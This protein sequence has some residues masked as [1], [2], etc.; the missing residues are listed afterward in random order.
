LAGRLPRSG[1]Y[2]CAG[3]DAY[4]LDKINNSH[5]AGIK[6]AIYK[7]MIVNININESVCTV[8][9]DPASATGTHNSSHTGI[10]D[11]VVG[12]TFVDK[13]PLGQGVTKGCP[14]KPYLSSGD[15]ND[16]VEHSPLSDEDQKFF[17]ELND[18][19]IGLLE[20]FVHTGFCLSAIKDFRLY[21]FTH[22]TFAAYCKETLNLEVLE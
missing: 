12:I 15:D 11:N 22:P 10:A 20:N 19:L 17:D 16:A 9:Q 4:Y 18:E 2:T 21:R 3:Q 1:S 6:Y 7:Y 8:K 13:D 14:Y 5:E